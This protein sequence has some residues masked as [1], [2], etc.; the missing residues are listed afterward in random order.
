MP[1]KTHNLLH[2]RFDSLLVIAKDKDF[3]HKNGTHSSTWVC[4]CDCGN[5]KTIIATSLLS[6]ATKS[7]GCLA[8]KT[9]TTH[10]KSK[11]RLYNTWTNIKQRCYNPK[12]NHYKNYGGRGI[13]VC[14]IWR[15][16]YTEFEHWAYN[17]GYNDTLTI[18]RIDNDGD[19]TPENCRWVTKVVQDNNKRTNVILEY[20]GESHTLMEWSKI[21]NVSYSMLQSRYKYGW[22]AKEIFE[23]P[24]H[25]HRRKG[26]RK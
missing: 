9:R 16:D 4:K 3:V 15:D 17:N 6:G 11:T 10:G 23:T 22:T 18:D 7:C 21:L 24:I 5:I 2:R 1:R 25:K 20:N 19:Y 12:N 13:K 14:D 8:L 26:D